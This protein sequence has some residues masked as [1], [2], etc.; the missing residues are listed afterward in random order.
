MLTSKRNEFIKGKGF[1]K[2]IIFLLLD[3][4]DIEFNIKKSDKEYKETI[5]LTCVQYRNLCNVDTNMIQFTINDKAFLDFLLVKK[6]GNQSL[7]QLSRK[8]KYL[9]KRD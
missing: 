8:I 7:T 3:K 6:G 1:W 9:K 5:C 4:D 2:F